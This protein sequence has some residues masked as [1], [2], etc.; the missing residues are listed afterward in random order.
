MRQWKWLFLTLS[1]IFAPFFVIKIDPKKFFRWKFVSSRKGKVGLRVICGW[2]SVMK[3]FFFCEK[4]CIK[5]S[6]SFSDNKH[7]TKSPQNAENLSSLQIS[8]SFCWFPIWSLSRY[9]LR[10]RL[11]FICAFGL[12]VHCIDDDDDQWWGSI[13]I[14]QFMMWFFERER[15]GF[16]KIRNVLK[17]H[18]QPIKKLKLCWTNLS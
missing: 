8:F 1:A 18:N 17:L 12:C 5:I 11:D 16:S 15:G 6:S 2:Q 14:T 9:E 13:W 10:F 4:V 7:Q 3:A